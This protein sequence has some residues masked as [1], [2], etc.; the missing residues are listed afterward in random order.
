MGGGAACLAV[1]THPLALQ[2][3]LGHGALRGLKHP[4]RWR[5]GEGDTGERC[6]LR[7]QAPW[8]LI[9]TPQRGLFY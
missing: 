5:W 9:L 3:P 2:F 6:W 8:A 1:D 4:L 7:S